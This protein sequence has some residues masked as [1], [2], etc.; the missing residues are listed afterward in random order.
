M[1]L[2]QVDSAQIIISTVVSFSMA[3]NSEKTHHHTL[4]AVMYP[5][6]TDAAHTNVNKESM[7]S[8]TARN[9][10]HSILHHGKAIAG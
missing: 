5:N 2:E 6:P 10:K 4:L 8:R 7:N 1:C 3:C 9:T